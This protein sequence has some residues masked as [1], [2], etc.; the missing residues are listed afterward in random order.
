MNFIK[1]A[2][3]YRGG[4]V[5]KVLMNLD[6]V[7]YAVPHPDGGTKI[8]FNGGD[9]C[10]AIPFDKFCSMFPKQFGCHVVDKEK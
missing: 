4:H 6:N 5:G 3:K 9:Y 7:D 8:Q 2:I 10:T 1:V